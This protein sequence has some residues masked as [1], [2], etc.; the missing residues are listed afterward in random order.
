VEV[1]SEWGLRIRP[2]RSDACD[3]PS[4]SSSTHSPTKSGDLALTVLHVRGTSELL[5]P[6]EL[7]IV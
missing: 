5:L 2:K 6:T 3:A 4:Q 1:V 7:S